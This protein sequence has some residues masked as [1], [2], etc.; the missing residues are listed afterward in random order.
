M[1]KTET[2]YINGREFIRTYSDAG[3][4]VVRDGIAYAEANDPAEF[5]R[6]YTEGNL[7]PTEE[8]EVNSEAEE[9]VD[10]LTGGAS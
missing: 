1:I 4:E 10:I 6:T 9:I 2:F 5:G 3:R 7:L 8:G